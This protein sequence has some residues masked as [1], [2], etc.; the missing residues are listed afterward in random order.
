L[1]AVTACP[2]NDRHDGDV[3]HQTA[4]LA[5]SIVSRIFEKNIILLFFGMS[6]DAAIVQRTPEKCA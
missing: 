5:S 6:F 3:F 1:A 2:C 4:A